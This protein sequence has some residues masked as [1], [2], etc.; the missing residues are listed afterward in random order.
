MPATLST[1]LPTE[2]EKRSASKVVEVL[3]RRITETGMQIPI[4][5]NGETTTLEI[6][7]P[8]ANLVIE[9]LVH[10]GNGEA[11]TLVPY[12]SE[13]STQQAADLLNVSRPYL[14][15]LIDSNMLPHHK[16]GR[17]RRILASD[18]LAYKAK[19]DEERQRG[20]KELTSIAQEANAL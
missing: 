2:D 13:L 20:L 3:A 16:V 15:K 1:R 18:L 10:I 7:T 5:E 11:V 4:S 6:P 8:V 9:L 19:R 14:I 17:H 12:G